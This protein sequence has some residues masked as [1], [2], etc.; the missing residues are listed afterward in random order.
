MTWALLPIGA[1]YAVFAW[2][3]WAFGVS[4]VGDSPVGRRAAPVVAVLWPLAIA[5]LVVVAISAAID[6]A[7]DRATAWM[8]NPEDERDD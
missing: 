3:I 8:R 4:L 5:F 2:L 7:Y 1:G 6:A